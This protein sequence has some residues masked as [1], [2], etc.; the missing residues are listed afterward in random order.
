MNSMNFSAA[1][2]KDDDMTKNNVKQIREELLMSK[3]ELAKMAGISPITIGRIET[4]F[5]CR[6]ETQRKIIKVLEYKLSERNLVFP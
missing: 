5:P 4:G 3:A 6:V 1:R 2:P